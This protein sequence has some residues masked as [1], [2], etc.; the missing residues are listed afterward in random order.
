MSPGSHVSDVDAMTCFLYQSILDP[1]LGRI[2]PVFRDMERLLGTDFTHVV[3]WNRKEE[4]ICLNF[5]TEA[6]V[7]SAA[8]L[9]ESYYQHVDPRRGIAAALDTGEV[10]ACHD[11][12]DHHYVS[13]NEFYQ[14][15][16]IPL[17]PRYIMAANIARNDTLDAHVV[18]NY[19]QG[20]PEFSASQRAKFKRIVPHLVNWIDLLSKFEVI[21]NLTQSFEAGLSAMQDGVIIFDACKRIGYV[22]PAGHQYLRTNAAGGGLRLSFAFEDAIEH[23][24]ERVIRQRIALKLATRGSTPS[25]PATFEISMVPLPRDGFTVGNE[26]TSVSPNAEQP[27]SSRVSF[28]GHFSSSAAMVVI[29]KLQPRR[30]D[31][32]FL[33]A[34]YGLTPAEADVAVAFIAGATLERLAQ[35]RKTALSTVRTQIRAITAKLGA[36]NLQDLIRKAALMPDEPRGGSG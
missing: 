2:I 24:L 23:A 35:S 28:L 34:Q 20:R 31:G 30:K 7:S 13:H 19:V 26:T 25:G 17:G 29:K 18:V 22:N 8:S 36:S 14:D 5:V 16:L 21:L 6:S 4:R 15:F 9:Y 11:Y 1:D 32:A 12:L 10:F 3:A 27:V 33:R